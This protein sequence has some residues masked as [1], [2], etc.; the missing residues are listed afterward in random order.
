MSERGPVTSSQPGAAVRPVADDT[1][2]DRLV[3]ARG[4]FTG[5]SAAVPD[6]MYT[7][8]RGRGHCERNALTLEKGARASTN[9]YFG[10]IPVSYFQ[11]WTTVRDFQLRMA[12]NA[13][14]SARVMLRGCDAH[15][16][17]RTITAAELDG[18]GVAT[19]TAPLNEYVDG[20]AMW[21][22]CRA[23]VGQLQI[24]DLE[25]TVPAPPS[26]RPA[27]IAM[28]TFNRADEC[29]AALAAIAADKGL[30]A[31]ITV[32]YLVDQG[33]DLITTRPLFD[34]IA[35]QLGDKLVYLRQSNLGGSGGFTRGIYEISRMGAPANVILMD[36]DILC[37][38]ESLLRLNAF[39][40][41]TETPAIVGAQMLFLRNTRRLHIQAERVDIE[42]LSASQMVPYGM[43]DTDMIEHRQNKRVDAQYNA[44]WSCLIPA[45]VIEGVGLPLPMFFT[46]DDIE[47]S[48]RAGAA[49]FPTISLPNAGVWHAEFHLK[50][51]D[52]IKGYFGI[53][54]A[55]I[56]YALHYDINTAKTTWW[57]SRKILDP[58]VS[59][60]Y[61]LGYTMMRGMEDYLAGPSVLH[62][63]GITALAAIRADRSQYPETI[64]H[65]ASD[66]TKLTG[67]LLQI[68]P[69]PRKYLKR[70]RLR[71]VLHNRLI[72]QWFGWTRG[73]P[74]AIPA[75]I[76]AWWYVGL[77]DY[78]IVTDASQA[79]VRVRRRDKAQL[80]KLS[81]RLIRLLYRFAT[82]ATSVQARWREALPELSGRQNWERLF[83]DPD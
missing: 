68:A 73:G 45:E 12:Y 74:V 52:D 61:G 58:L 1:A 69:P 23:V 80:V 7:R 51:R 42:R 56:T 65:P 41:V 57:L 27:A 9:T 13:V 29:A 38:P 35:A 70:D 25:W 30:L 44:W 37:E 72:R 34:D 62:D 71:V 64:V 79:G 11:R 48:V 54:N 4:L 63:G 39:A 50:D 17:E 49:G 66:I 53:R 77:Y 3:V 20:G 5:V 8:I 82:Q 67:S 78:A 59:M 2:P 19:L 18:T 40:N 36:D 43:R 83:G 24:T 6:E 81:W 31:G 47:Y 28:T 26:T 14:G 75:E 10:R 21:M 55:M 32:I 15:G 46:W 16:V 33:T 60:Q 22:E 76:A